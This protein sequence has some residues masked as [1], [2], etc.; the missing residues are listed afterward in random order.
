M[1][2]KGQ[3]DS[4]KL[5]EKLGHTKLEIT[6]GVLLGIAVSF[7]YQFFIASGL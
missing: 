4:L 1:L 7:A 2:E 5:K 6:V 3:L